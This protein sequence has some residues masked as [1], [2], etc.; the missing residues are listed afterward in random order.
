MEKKT[1]IIIGGA[2]LALVAG[3]G[4]FA[5]QG[6]KQHKAMKR[7]FSPQAMMTQMDTNGDL[8]ISREELGAGVQKHFAN[9]DQNKDGFV[10]KAELVTTIEGM[11]V[12]SRLKRRSGK[13]A[14]R[15]SGQA[16]VNQDGKI[17]VSEVEN[18]MMKLHALADWNDDGLVEIAE[19]KRLRPSHHGR[20]GKG[21]RGDRG[22]DN[23]E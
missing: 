23:A 16:D 21:K 1:K 2:V 11:E 7:M 18:R 22:G 10:T 14:D 17:A 15:I 13:I 19:L 12:P 4:A 20:G 5:S 3:G 9:A 6:Y 8:S